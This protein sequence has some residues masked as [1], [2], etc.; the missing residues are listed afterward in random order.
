LATHLHHAEEVEDLFRD[1]PS[2][3]N[4][5]SAVEGPYQGWVAAPVE[6]GRVLARAGL[7]VSPRWRL[8]LSGGYEGS[9][10]PLGI[11]A[12]PSLGQLPFILQAHR[13]FLW[14]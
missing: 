1:R 14:K 12:N 13:V 8:E 10:S 3:G 6:R 4:G 5:E 9:P 2:S 11:P 7:A